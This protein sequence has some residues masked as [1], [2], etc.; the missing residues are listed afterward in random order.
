MDVA[1]FHALNRFGFGPGA[2]PTDPKAW[3]QAQLSEPDTGPN[4]APSTIMALEALKYDRENKPS[5]GNRRVGRCT[6]RMRWRC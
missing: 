1:A 2:P 5:P 4:P 3:L 6:G